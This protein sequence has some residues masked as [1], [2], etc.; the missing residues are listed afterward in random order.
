MRTVRGR[1]VAAM[2][3]VVGLV[4]CGDDDDAGSGATDTESVATVAASGATDSGSVATGTENVGGG[5]T[6]VAAN[7]AFDP[8]ELSV[9]AG[10]TITLRN[11]DDVE[12]SFTIDDPELDAEA[13]GG[14][15]ATVAAP[16]EPGTYDFHCRYHPDQ[17]KGTLTV[18]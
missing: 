9:A 7:I 16:E 17:M 4:A 10:E 12:H 2:V 11:E 8:T 18:E 15:E 3:V 5:V 13:E 6:I 14:E 1:V